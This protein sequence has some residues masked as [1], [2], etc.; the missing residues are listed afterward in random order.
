MGII[1]S[2]NLGAGKI[3][4]AVKASWLGVLMGCVL[5]EL[6]GLAAAS[7]PHVWIGMFS[8]DPDVLRV[9]ADFRLRPVCF[10]TAGYPIGLQVIGDPSKRRG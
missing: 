3:D 6:V 1:V 10:A 5:T 2:A 8:Q 9:G 4:R 7:F